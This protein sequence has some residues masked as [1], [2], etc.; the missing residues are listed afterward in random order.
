MTNPATVQFP[1]SLI[2]DVTIQPTPENLNVPNINTAALFTNE[3]PSWIGSQAFKI[4]TNA[5]EIGVDFGTGSNSFKIATKFFAQQPN[6]I[7]TGGYLVLIPRVIGSS[8]TVQSA[9][10]RTLNLVYYFGVL[11]DSEY[12]SDQATFLSLADYVQG[13]QKM[14]FYASSNTADFASGGLLDLV[15][16]H[17]DQN[18]QCFYYNDGTSIDTPCFAAGVAGRALSTNFNGSNTTESINLKTIVGFAADQTLDTTDL[19]ACQAAG[20]SVYISIGGIPKLY[21]SGEN[22]WFDEVYNQFWFGFALQ[23]A[24]FNYLATS[25]T[26]IPQTEIG[27]EGLK[28]VYRKVCQQAVTNGFIAPGSWTSADTFGPNGAL[29][30][31]I[32]DQGYYVFSQPIIDQDPT[33]RAA[34][35][36]PLVQIAIKAAGAIQHSDVIV[37]VNL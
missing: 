28:N 23:T 33:D 2:I 34:R 9:V 3:Q 8:E 37:N 18:T 1:V 36:A 29:V 14:M 15:R 22:G 10:L 27:M 5:S 7:G 16:Q 20:V 25:A 26:K 19:V 17:G 32:G 6:P 21:T 13:L 30:R 35:N 24:G 12:S 4:Y 31:N 11:V